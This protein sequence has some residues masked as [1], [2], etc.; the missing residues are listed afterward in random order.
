MR[1]II[2]TPD[3]VVSALSALRSALAGLC[4]ELVAPNDLDLDL[5]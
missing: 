3:G 5:A 4:K 1:F 2:L